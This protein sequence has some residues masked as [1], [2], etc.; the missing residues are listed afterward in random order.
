MRWWAVLS[1]V[2]VAGCT[3]VRLEQRSGCWLKQTE[4][5]GWITEE[6]GP[7][8]KPATEWVADRPTRLV[9]ECVADASWRWQNRALAMWQRGEPLPE[10]P[11]DQ[12]LLEACQVEAARTV[13]QQNEAL[14][15]RLEGA[16]ADR[17]RVLTHNEHLADVLGEA[18]QKPAGSATAT[19]NADGRS[20]STNESMSSH[21]ADVSSPAPVVAPAP[22]VVP[23]QPAPEPVIV[24]VTPKPAPVAK[25]VVSRPKP[26][27]APEKLVCEPR[28]DCEC[29]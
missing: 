13:T 14:E 4:K 16:L 25:P 10:Q 26:P 3:T 6:L 29:D 24:R 8:A 2:C 28:D 15:V 20:S 9:Q 12:T 27:P 19:A 23:Y 11:S 21:D 7:C 17:D 1:V 18:A 22:I 5:W